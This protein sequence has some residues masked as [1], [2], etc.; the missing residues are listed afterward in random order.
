[1]DAGHIRTTVAAEL[2]LERV[3]QAFELSEGGHVRGK[4]VLR[5]TPG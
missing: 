3:D 2:P 4:V 1:V 5:V